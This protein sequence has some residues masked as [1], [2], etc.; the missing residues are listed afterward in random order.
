MQALEIEAIETD[1]A[2][3]AVRVDKGALSAADAARFAAWRAADLRH[4]R[5]YRA[6]AADF[7]AL[8]RMPELT[9]LLGEPTWRE[10]AVARWQAVRR[11]VEGVMADAVWRPAFK[12]AAA[13]AVFGAGAVFYLASQPPSYETRVAELRDLTLA[14]GSVVTLGASSRIEV[15][16]SAG[17]R[18]IVL[19]R[20]EAF[21]NVAKDHARPFTVAAGD[22]KARAVGTKFD[23]HRGP[24]EVRVA[25]MEGVVEVTTQPLAAPADPSPV[26]LSPAAA[27]QTLSAGQE[28]VAPRAGRPAP[29][30][31]AALAHT[32]GWR[33][34]RLDYDG[35]SLREVVADVNRYYP[36]RVALASEDLGGLKVTTSFRATQIDQMLDAIAGVLSLK[37]DRNANG[38]IVLSAKTTASNN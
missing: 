1:A 14:D 21:F 6:A 23:V 27:V 37:V 18:R 13:A 31:A 36:G 30:R 25:V 3:W 34:G 12:G 24:D 38:R 26:D 11:A 17:E 19:I 28:I 9:A 10:R 4:E 5:A 15:K 33:S 35:V 8:S 22:T 2:D 7:A 16:F 29:V 20:G 32:G